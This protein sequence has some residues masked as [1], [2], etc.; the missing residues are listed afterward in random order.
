MIASPCG[1]PSSRT[2]KTSSPLRYSCTDG[3][4]GGVGRAIRGRSKHLSE[5]VEHRSPRSL[6]GW[7]VIAHSRP[8]IEVSARAGEAVLR[9][10]V[11]DQPP[12][13][14]PGT[15]LFLEGEPLGGGYQRVFVAHA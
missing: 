1:G 11:E 13:H 10:A 7:T 2:S 12:I 8:A 5:E 3:R 4:L 14:A 15:H 9:A 6:V